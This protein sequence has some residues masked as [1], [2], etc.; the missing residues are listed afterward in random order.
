M[1]ETSKENAKIVSITV[2]AVPEQAGPITKAA[3]DKAP[4]DVTDITY[5]AVLAAP[6]K[7]AVIASSAAVAFLSQWTK[8]GF[9]DNVVD[10]IAQTA[11][12][13][14]K[15]ALGSTNID[16]IRMAIREAIKSFC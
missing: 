8:G 13:A 3:V 14:Q 16:E 9:P 5:A 6:D 11:S 15:E 2:A 1:S 4:D 12:A 10:G 7:A